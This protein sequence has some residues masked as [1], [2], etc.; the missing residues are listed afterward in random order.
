MV[1]LQPMIFSNS[2]KIF[3]NRVPKGFDSYE[4]PLFLQNEALTFTMPAEVLCNLS[5]YRFQMLIPH[6][7]LKYPNSNLSLYCLTCC[8]QK[9]HYFGCLTQGIAVALKCGATKAQFD[10]TVSLTSSS[11]LILFLSFI[12]KIIDYC[13]IP[14]HRQ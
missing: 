3:C 12:T 13:L 4:L 6:F 11:F 5:L 2:T 7:V 1:Q 9:S 10:S 14:A 8:L